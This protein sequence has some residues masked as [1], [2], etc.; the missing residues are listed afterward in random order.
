[1][2]LHNTPK[3]PQRMPTIEKIL[4]SCGINRITLIEQISVIIAEDKFA[5][6]IIDK[7]I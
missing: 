7:G 5:S 6:F 2:A 4:F 3:I 1:M